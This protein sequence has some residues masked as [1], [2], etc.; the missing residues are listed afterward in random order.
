MPRPR[1]RLPPVTMTYAYAWCRAS[2]PVAVTSSDGTKRIAAGTLCCGKRV[3][4]GLQDLALQLPCDAVGL[5]P[6]VGF[7]AQHHVGDDDRAGDRVLAR[8]APATCARRGWRLITAS[9][10]SG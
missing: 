5:P 9:T 7:V 4:A 1:P 10:S 2:L 8:R 3:A 6:A